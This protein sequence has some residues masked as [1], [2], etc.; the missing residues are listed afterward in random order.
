VVRC[1]GTLTLDHVDALKTA[2]RAVITENGS[3]QVDLA[4]VDYVDS[5]GL[6]A[7][8]SL[9]TSARTAHCQFKLINFNERIADVLHI[10]N[11]LWVLT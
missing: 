4:G 11:L 3:V 5:A 8:V 7:L 1:S 9:Y 10:T 2:V 6:G